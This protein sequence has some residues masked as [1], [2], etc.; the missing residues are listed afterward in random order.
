M[1]RSD[2]HVKECLR[3]FAQKSPVDWTQDEDNPRT[4][5]GELEIGGTEA[6][7]RLQVPTFFPT[8]L[9]DV[10]VEP[11]DAFGFIPH[12]QTDGLVCYQETEGMVVDR[13]SPLSILEG[14][15]E[16]ALSVLRN[17]ASGNN[18]D[19]FAE[20]FES[21]WRRLESATSLPSLV[22]ATDQPRL[23]RRAKK[24]DTDFLADSEEQI[25]AFLNGSSVKG[26]FT[27]QKALYVPL[28]KSA[29]VIP[30][31]PDESLWSEEK[32][33]EVVWGN[34]ASAFKSEVRDLCEELS[35]QTTTIVLGIPKETEGRSLVGIRY[36]GVEAEHPL[37]P[38]SSS[39][40]RIPLVLSRMDHGYIAP[41]SGADTELS[42]RSV[43]L[44]GGGAV[45]GHLSFELGRAGVGQIT[46]VDPEKLR[47]EN[48]YRHALGRGHWSDNKARA[49]KARL[50]SKLPYLKCEAVPYKI[51]KA[52]DRGEL[53]LR[54]YDLIVCATGDMTLELGLNDHRA[55]IGATLPLLH[56]WLEPYGIGGHVL[57]SGNDE[58]GCLECLF[59]SSSGDKRLHN[60][61][62]F[63]QKGQE[64]G[65]RLAGCGS[66][67]TPYGSADALRTAELA[68]RM[69]TEVLTGRESGSPLRSWKGDPGEF[70]A[71]GYRL[72]NRFSL[73][74][75]QLED[76]K[77][78]YV[79]GECP[80]C[81]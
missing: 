44:V 30:P 59:T 37:L 65:R 22:E 5:V 4:V 18:E 56:A 11:W 50:E 17:G 23:I 36:K 69:A 34:V 35:G 14:V 73:T 25:S 28:K 21:Y 58:A 80:V 57:V 52:L 42:S 53:D 24:E 48:T 66:L 40:K 12:V 71:E 8:Q 20:E 41:R 72:S 13:R 79:A 74:S 70:L 68:T 29:R 31:R 32:I 51:Q 7:L 81:G 10:Y 43:L 54:D 45:G 75:E 16:K 55:G 6:T 46:L 19:V 39:W 60:R 47:P 1:T 33:R 78:A 9:P 64:F 67:H 62:A 26:D 2:D 15:L 76:Q 77:Y 63:A 27:I 3:Q 49:L 61:A 38:E